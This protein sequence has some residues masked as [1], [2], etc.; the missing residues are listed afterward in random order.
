MGKSLREIS[1][2]EDRPNE[3]TVYAWL[4]KHKYFSEKYRLAGE[5]RTNKIPDEAGI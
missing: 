1:E 3:D 4:A 5:H 2:M